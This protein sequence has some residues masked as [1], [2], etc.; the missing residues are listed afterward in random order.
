MSPHPERKRATVR[1]GLRVLELRSEGLTMDEV[2]SRMGLTYR[3]V[4]YAWRKVAR[5]KEARHAP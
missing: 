4:N 1:R 3:Q 2:C 5:P